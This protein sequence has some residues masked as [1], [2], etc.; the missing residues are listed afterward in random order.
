MN[1]IR[2]SHVQKVQEVLQLASLWCAFVKRC[3]EASFSLY[4]GENYN[5]AE[6][7]HAQKTLMKV[8]RVWTFGAK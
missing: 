1:T 8:N 6:V 3:G 4:G 5:E 2:A 7:A